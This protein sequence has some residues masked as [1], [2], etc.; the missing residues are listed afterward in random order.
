MFDE[1]FQNLPKIIDAASKSSLGVISLTITSISLSILL[2]TVLGI[3]LFRKH[4]SDWLIITAFSFIVGVTL[5]GFSINRELSILA[6]N[7]STPSPRNDCAE[8]LQAADKIADPVFR[9]DL[10]KT[11]NTERIKLKDSLN[12]AI[13]LLDKVSNTSCTVEAIRIKHRYMDRRELINSYLNNI[14]KPTETPKLENTPI[15]LPPP[16]TDNGREYLSNA[17][18][19]AN[20][21]SYSLSPAKTI[22]DLKK[23]KEL[24]KSAQSSLDKISKDNTFR[25]EVK[26]E[27]KRYSSAIDKINELLND[28]NK[29]PVPEYLRNSCFVQ[30]FGQNCTHT[31]ISI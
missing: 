15:K 20:Q 21:A 12:N 31:N 8:V 23:A 10:E 11:N 22:N 4:K 28:L 25:E 2:L 30:L 24:L 17:R 7:S 19:L 5:L 1:L 6:L 29:T 26:T 16:P 9:I 13:D 3:S 14:S 18:N 27:Y